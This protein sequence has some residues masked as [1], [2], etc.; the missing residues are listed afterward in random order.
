MSK[1]GKHVH[2]SVLI[3]LYLCVGDIH[4]ES[5]FGVG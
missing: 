5:I 2:N 1:S 4:F 3:T